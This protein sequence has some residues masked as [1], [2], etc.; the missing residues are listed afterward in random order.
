MVKNSS[1]NARDSDLV[2]DQETKIPRAMGKL[3]LHTESRE[4]YMSRDKDPA[5]PKEENSTN[6]ICCS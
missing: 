5:Q 1:C 6:C 4:V 3:S 2:P